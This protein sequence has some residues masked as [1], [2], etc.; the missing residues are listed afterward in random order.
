MN[1]VRILHCADLHFDTQM[2]KLSKQDILDVFSYIIDIALEENVEIMLIAGDVFD[3]LSVNKQTLNFLESAFK[4]IK[5]IKVFISPGNHDPYN[6]KSFY[7]LVDWP[8]NVHIFKGDIEKIYI[9]ELNL[10]IYGAGFKSNYINESNLKVKA[11]KDKINIMVLHGELTTSN[12]KNE[13]NPITL[14]D[15]ESSDLDYLALGHRHSFTGIQKQDKT[16]Y[17]YSGCPQGRGF[18]ELDEK[19]IILGDVYSGGVNLEFRKTSKRMYKEVSIDINTANSYG[20]VKSIILSEIEKTD[21]ENNLYKIFLVGEINE[22]F[23]IKA[24]MIYEMIKNEF[25]YVK[26]IDK[27][28]IKYDYEELAKANSIKG[29]FVKTLLEQLDE[30]EGE[31]KEIIKEAIKLG[32]RALSEDEVNISDY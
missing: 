24:E 6:H 32:L 16:Y 13:Y 19:G 27:T 23:I 8:D 4:S 2:S 29:I 21:R 31:D 28:E 9:E 11:D 17:A 18:D 7:K 15:I 25:Y 22:E 14:E 5:N 20:E 10:N 30:S 1:K 12:S 3:N 26:L